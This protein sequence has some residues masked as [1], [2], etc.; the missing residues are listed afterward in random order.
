MKSWQHGV[1]IQTLYSGRCT[2]DSAPYFDYGL[3]QA[4]SDI[5][6]SLLF[7]GTINYSAGAFLDSPTAIRAFGELMS[8][9][10]FEATRLKVSWTPLRLHTD[11]PAKWDGIRAYVAGRWRDAAMRFALFRE[12]DSDFKL[13]SPLDTYD[14]RMQAADAIEGERSA[15]HPGLLPD[16]LAPF[17]KAVRVAHHV[18]GEPPR[19]GDGNIVTGG[20]SDAVYG[21]I[22]K[23]ADKSAIDIEAILRYVD[24]NACFHSM[25]GETHRDV[26]GGFPPRMA[27]RSRTDAIVRQVGPDAKDFAI[28][29]FELDDLI[30]SNT[31]FEAL[32]SS[33]SHMN[34]LHIHGSAGLAQ[35]RFGELDWGVLLEIVSLDE[36]PRHV[37]RIRSAQTK[38]AAFAAAEALLN[39]LAKR[40]VDFNFQLINGRLSA[41]SKVAA[42]AA[43]CPTAASV[44]LGHFESS[45]VSL[46]G[47]GAFSAAASALAAAVK[48]ASS[49][50]IMLPGARWASERYVDRALR[51]AITP[52]TYLGSALGTSPQAR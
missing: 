2:S 41:S 26:L 16:A 39:L 49:A 33:E 42:G 6:F 32:A 51:T 37:L 25:D 17:L 31:R 8:H 44:C 52:A 4:R 21:P 27:I 10:L 23:D 28:G 7:G 45:L 36:W 29:R 46:A 13:E 22:L 3:A 12:V 47:A 18:E 43:V 1:V 24:G 9:P 30:E 20:V 40:I 11:N 14:L 38:D 48:S 5:F 15:T 34:A 50:T 35:E 19:D